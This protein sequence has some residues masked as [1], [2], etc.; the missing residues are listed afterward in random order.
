MQ[1]VTSQAFN[2]NPTAVKRSA[3]KGPVRI[4]ERGKVS[5][6]LLSIDDYEAI[7]G[8]SVNIVDMLAMR[9]EVDNFEFEKLNVSSIKPLEFD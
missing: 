7:T 3:N 5:H 9:A 6:V 2:Q 4:T 8:Q 1:T